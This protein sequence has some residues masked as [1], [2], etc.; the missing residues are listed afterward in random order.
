MT[1]HK[2]PHTQGIRLECIPDNAEQAHAVLSREGGPQDLGLGD[3]RGGGG[4]E[5][6]EDLKDR[7]LGRD[8]SAKQASEEG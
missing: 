8:R 6:E 3:S 1:S 2:H 4:E 5:E 7:D